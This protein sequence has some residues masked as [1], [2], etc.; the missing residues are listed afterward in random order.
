LDQKIIDLYDD[1]THGGMNRRAFLDRLAALAGSTVAATAIL[2]VLQNDYAHAQTIP[3]TD[4][5]ITTETVDIP[6]VQ[7]LKGYLVKPKAGANK[8]PAVIVI[9]ENRGLNP[10]IKDVTRRMATDGFLALGLDYLSPMGGTPTD[11]DKGRD[12]IGQLKQPDVIASG[13]A[14]VAYLKGRPDSTGKVGAVGFCWGGGAV[15]N[16]AVND[17]EL[18]A[19]VAYYGGQPK[20]EDVPKIRAALMLHYGGLDERVNAGIP[21]YEAALKQAGK[22]YELHVYEGAN[23][24]FNNDTNAAR[25][26]KAAADLAW[27]RTT[28]FLKKHLA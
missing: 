6:G 5:R 4:P 18:S 20:A 26:D 27:S 8:L 13:K 12:M 25:Y 28:S 15:N 1:F 2:S 22:T 14:A 3:E 23:H 24:A 10:H 11:E 7:G 9:H 19:G 21:A 17:P 16:L